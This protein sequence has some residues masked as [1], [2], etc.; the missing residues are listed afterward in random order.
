MTQ[1]V[2]EPKADMN[3][4]IQSISGF[5]TELINSDGLANHAEVNG[6]LVRVFGGGMGLLGG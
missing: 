5:T 3:M 4:I 2:T 6:E 1:P